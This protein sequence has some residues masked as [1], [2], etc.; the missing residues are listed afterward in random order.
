MNSN[1]KT[2]RNGYPIP[3]N[4]APSAML[5]TVINPDYSAMQAE[6]HLA[7]KEGHE[8]MPA[9]LR[10]RQCERADETLCLDCNSTLIAAL[11]EVNRYNMGICTDMDTATKLWKHPFQLLFMSS[12]STHICMQ[13]ATREHRL[14]PSHWHRRSVQANLKFVDQ[15]PILYTRTR[16][17]WACHR[18]PSIMRD[19]AHSRNV[20]TALGR[21]TC[22]RRSFPHGGVCWNAPSRKT[23]IL[24]CHNSLQLE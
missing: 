21:R 23:A 12:T 3:Q 18:V 7:G 1:F 20:M 22:R 10:F 9:H 17:W 5:N 15:Y 19:E 11:L 4:C 6:K 14:R 8:R 16:S 13:H 24:T 2:T